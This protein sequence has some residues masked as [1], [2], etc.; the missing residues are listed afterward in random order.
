MNS[1]VAV[2]ATAFM[3]KDRTHDNNGNQNLFL[4]PIAGKIPNKTLVI[5]GTI[6]NQLGI[7]LG[8][9]YLLGINEG[10]P[11]DIFGRQF[12]VTN[13]GGLSPL[14][15]LKVV[16]ELGNAVVIDVTTAAGPAA[17]PAAPVA[18]AVETELP[19]GE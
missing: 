16:N 3:K 4:N 14:D 12:S 18:T 8:K 17:A 6:A 15:M 19:A 7:E 11:S 13:L 1:I 5:S 9:S 2:N 10:K